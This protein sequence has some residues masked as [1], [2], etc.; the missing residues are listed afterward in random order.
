MPGDMRRITQ[1]A[2][3]MAAGV[4]GAGAQPTVAPTA[5]VLEI[6]GAIGPA[7]ASYTVRGIER[8]AETGSEIVV[9]T[10]DTPGGLDTS[11][12]EIIQAMLGSP[13]PI[14][15]Y[16][17]PQGAR[18]ASAGT[19]ILYAS[20]VAAMA[21]ATNLG[22]AT[23]VSIGGPAAP[24]GADPGDADNSS[25]DASRGTP[26]DPSEPR[27]AEERKAVNDAVAY[28]RGLAEQRGRNADWAERAVRSAASLSAR[29]AL[30]Q[31]VID[32]IADDLDDLLAQLDGRTV[33]VAGGPRTL[34]TADIA[35]ERVEPDWRTR[36]LAVITNPT[37]AYILMLIG[38]YG[39]IFEGY[40]P[41]AILPGV[42]G[43]ISLLLALYAFQILP[44]DYAGLALIALGVTLM[45]AEFMVP[46][47][48]VLGIGGIAA[49]V[50]G[51][52]I[53]IDTDVPG[54]RVPTPLLATLA[55]VGS[56]AVLGTIWIAVRTRALPVVSGAEDFARSTATALEDFEREGNVRV[57]GER[58]RARSTVP[59]RKGDSLRIVG[60][61][62]LVLQVEPRE[63]KV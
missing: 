57:G 17:T 29:A 9:L 4:C 22:A 37:V 20:H 35:V 32:L 2:A 47:F 61:D 19:Y 46:S 43:A 25:D 7:T 52:V 10:I 51:S 30:E 33:D 31:R 36:L 58:W 53:L 62:N 5:T 55:T 16:V 11:M 41:G 60:V 8:A 48:G 49:F 18:A 59:I 54:F 42:V 38:I 34:A 44:I 27:T 24:P 21:P 50:F 56:A 39:L 28:I 23:P 1:I 13:V 15:A 63:P 40:S 26:A 3:L 14:V 12:R 6:D 45:I